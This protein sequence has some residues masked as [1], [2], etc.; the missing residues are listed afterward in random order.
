MH[1]KT[2]P[3]AP[4]QNGAQHDVAKRY[5]KSKGAVSQ[6]AT[7]I[8]ILFLDFSHSSHPPPQIKSQHNS[9]AVAHED[10]EV[11][12][13]AFNALDAM[14]LLLALC[15]QVRSVDHNTLCQKT[16]TESYANFIRSPVKIIPVQV[17]YRQVI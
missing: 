13:H 16:F 3:H 6:E 11:V 10:R 1:A 14:T 7:P 2:S 15:E 12:Q 9:P 4:F 5:A 8:I 17:K